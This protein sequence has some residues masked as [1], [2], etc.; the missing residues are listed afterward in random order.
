MKANGEREKTSQQSLRGVP[1]V[2]RVCTDT[3]I[4]LVYDPETRKTGLAVSRFGG[5]WNIEQE[6]QV[7]TGEILVPYSPRNNLIAN[8]CVLLPAKPEESRSKEELLA[9]VRAFLH[10]YVDLSPLFED[11]AVHYVLLTWVYD[12][13]NELGYLRLRGDYGT[14]K[15]RAL[16]AL[17]SLCYKAF[18]ASGASTVSPIFHVLDS[19]CG[20]LIFDEAD[21]PFSDAKADMVKVF[22]NG[23]MRGIP[24]LR[25]VMNRQKEFNPQAFKV[26]GPKI[27][28]MRGS[29]D[30]RALESRFLTEET[31]TRPLRSDVPLYLPA[32]M[33]AEALELR[34]RLLHFRLC[35]FFAIKTDTTALM[36]NVEPRLN[37]TALSLLSLVD[38][39]D[40]RRA[41]QA[42]L[43]EENANTLS[44]RRETVEGE[45]LAS[46]VE[47]FSASDGGNVSLREIAARF[48]VA[49]PT[50]YGGP[51][52]NKWIGH[53]LRKR[54]R[55]TTCKSTGIYV[56]PV[57]EKP[58]I[59][60]LAARVGL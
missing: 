17:G 5:L 46:V 11:I 4:E 20:T 37:Q 44:E 58:K 15:T 28:A 45:V 50:E 43:I 23:T 55:I 34:N 13:F 8:D 35:N 27:I 52:S 60:A 7:E 32:A 56:V 47:A 19:F 2:S 18:F 59:D 25:T 3:L 40:V 26:Y 36:E 9:D 51:M 21:L 48:N 57:S 1:T 16:M 14:G 39:P 12:A 22:N 6:V 24:V 33:K 54:L 38:D 42:A 30:D 31:G 41:I 53:V 49:H 10:R 29:F